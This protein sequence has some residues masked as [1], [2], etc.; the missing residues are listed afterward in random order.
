MRL[1]WR[2]HGDA[3]GLIFFVGFLSVIREKVLGVLRLRLYAGCVGYAGYQLLC[4]VCLAKL[5]M[6]ESEGKLIVW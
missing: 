2:E 5:G 3:T 4:R 6:W 1:Y